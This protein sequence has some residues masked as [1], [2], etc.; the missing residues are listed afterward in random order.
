M[1]GT[2]DVAEDS[3]ERAAVWVQEDGEVGGDEA[4]GGEGDERGEGVAL[5]IGVEGGEVVDEEIFGGVHEVA[6]AGTL[7]A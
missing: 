6:P 1:V 2:G 5:H 7:Q 4:C 3:A